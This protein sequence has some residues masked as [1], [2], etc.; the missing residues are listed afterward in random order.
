MKSTLLILLFILINDNIDKQRLY[1]T[2]IMK[3]KNK[4]I[5]KNIMKLKYIWL[6][7]ILIGL[8]ACNDVEDILAENNVETLSDEPLPELTSGSAN[9]SSFVALG[10]SNT[11]GMTDGACL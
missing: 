1:V 6:L 4:H 11:S 9:F 10:D 2:K 3:V 5:K 7:L 8:T